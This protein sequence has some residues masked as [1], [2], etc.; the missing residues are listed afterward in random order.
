M[1]LDFF[2]IE[3]VIEELAKAYP[4]QCTTTWFKIIRNHKPTVEQYRSKV[5]EYMKQFRYLLETYPQSPET[6]KLKELVNKALNEEIEKVLQGSN[7]GVERRYKHYVDN[8]PSEESKNP[9]EEKESLI[10]KC[11]D[12]TV[13]PDLIDEKKNQEYEDNMLHDHD[14]DQNIQYEEK[15]IDNTK[16]RR[17]KIIKYNDL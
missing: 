15:K 10:K 12:S 9:L 17:K 14:H 2:E 16:R 4:A 8:S 7:S 11:Y 1:S 3:R 6:D 13:S 5:V